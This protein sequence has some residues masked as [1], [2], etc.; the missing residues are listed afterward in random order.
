MRFFW[1]SGT[2]ELTAFSEWVDRIDG[3]NRRQGTSAP[4]LAV[5]W[6][7]PLD[8]LGALAT[9]RELRPIAIDEVI[10]EARSRFDKYPGN[11]RNHDL[12]LRGM[13]NGAEL[14]VCVEAKA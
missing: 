3:K 6:S 9:C 14:V 4:T 7:G 12:V 5:A 8:V 1:R 2:D 13:A 10:V 11:V